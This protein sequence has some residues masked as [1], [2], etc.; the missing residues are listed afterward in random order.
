MFRGRAGTGL[1]YV[2]SE[3]SLKH[4]NKTWALQF[5]IQGRDEQ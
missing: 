2:E 3:E 1:G 4:L 5:A